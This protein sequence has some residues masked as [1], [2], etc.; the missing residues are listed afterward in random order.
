MITREQLAS[1]QDGFKSVVESGAFS[2]LEA[3]FEQHSLQG[4]PTAASIQDLGEVYIRESGIKSVF[5][6]FREFAQGASGDKPADSF[7]EEALEDDTETM[8]N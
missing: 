3:W 2:S 5:R 6:S 8:L 4:N 1:N 7:E